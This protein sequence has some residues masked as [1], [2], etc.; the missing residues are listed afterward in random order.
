MNKIKF[1]PIFEW[2]IMKGQNLKTIT[3][4]HCHVAYCN[5]GCHEVSLFFVLLGFG[6]FVTINPTP[7]G[8]QIKVEEPNINHKKDEKSV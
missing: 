2:R 4:I 5:C 7:V 1:H 3:F 6:F 8:P